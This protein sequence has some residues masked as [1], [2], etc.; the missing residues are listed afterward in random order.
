MNKE[1]FVK[2]VLRWLQRDERG[3]WEKASPDDRKS[4]LMCIEDNFNRGFS[5]IDCLN[6]TRFLE[7]FN[8]DI[9][10]D[11]ALKRMSLI[12]KKYNQE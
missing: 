7:H 9:A 3:Y 10:E 11:E 2:K 8:P 1:E 4:I 5:W 12:M 6:Y